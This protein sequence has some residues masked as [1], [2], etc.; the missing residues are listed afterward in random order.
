MPTPGSGSWPFPHLWLDEYGL[1]S[2]GDYESAVSDD[3][4]GDGYTAWQEYVAGTVP[5]NAE[6]VF[7][8]WIAVSNG[9]PFISW[10]P[11]WEPRASTRSRASLR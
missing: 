1:V 9:L 4:D 2:N 3:T 7:T 10:V 11:D 6:S 8:A 5:T